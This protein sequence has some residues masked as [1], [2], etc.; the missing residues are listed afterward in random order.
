MWLAGRTD[1][2]RRWASVLALTLLVGLAGT[3]VLTAATGA[4]RADSALDRFLDSTK[5]WDGSIEADYAATDAVV[6]DVA[7]Q[8]EVAAASAAFLVP[9]GSDELQG[10]VIAGLASGWLRDVY[11]PRI[12]SGRLPDPR[13]DDEL[14]VNEDY[15]RRYRLVPG[16]VV[17]LEDFIGAGIAQPMTIVGIHRGPIDL[18]LGDTYPGAIAT[19]AFGRRY[20]K[21]ISAVVAG[22]PLADQ[23][24]PQV[25]ARM[26]GEV[27]DPLPILAEVAD[28]HADARPRVV[29]RSPFVAPLESA[30]A[31]QVEAFWI[32]TAVSGVSALLLLGMAMARL[33]AGGTHAPETLRALGLGSTSRMLVALVAPVLVAIV[34]GVLA[35]A[36]AVLASPLVP[37]GS[38][39]LVEPVPGIW[40]DPAALLAGGAVLIVALLAVAAATALIVGRVDH[41]RAPRVPRSRRGNRQLPLPAVLGRDLAY[42]ES[43]WGR[44]ALAAVGVGLGLVVSVVV[45]TASVDRLIDSPSLFG[46]DFE[47]VLFPPE[48]TNNPED[49]FAGVDLDQPAVES[50]AI[51][52]GA[53]VRVAGDLLEAQV[54]EPVRGVAGGTILRGRAPQAGDEVALGPTT[55]N[56]LGLEVGDDVTIAGTRRRSMRIV[57]EAVLPPPGQ[58]AYGDVLWLTPAAAERLEVEL[59]EP[60]LLVDVAEGIEPDAFL[61]TIDDDVFS[62]NEVLVPDEVSNL[63]DFGEIPIALMIFGVVLSGAVLAFALVGIVRRR[64]HDLAIL[65]TL[66]LRPRQ[67][68][69]SVF[70]AGLFIVGPGA[71]IGVAIGVV[72]GRAY[73]ASVAA[74]VPAVAQSVVPLALTALV[75]LGTLVVG[76]LL[77]VGPARSAGRLRPAEILRRD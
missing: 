50:A 55:A 42:R 66:G 75:V 15:A 67:V 54:I 32:L 11:R 41:R 24:R 48:L 77:V 49:V 63:D 43:G 21:A 34:G 28:R 18:A 10:G 38:G 37:L 53:Q 58:A 71:V 22:T 13:R 26:K 1:V 69:A 6:A 14:L 45:Y 59:Q 46:S 2:R 3:F 33:A 44:L 76:C 35:L 27:G 56:R 52:R 30:L 16:D 36:G 62:A 31:V 9:V 61:A 40:V 19:E 51:T 4:R 7:A 72:L 8:P 65:R 73:W 64:R 20:G 70:A 29:G 57:G 74:R 17:V 47:V 60:E 23:I 12:I 39:R 25:V 5:M 68:R